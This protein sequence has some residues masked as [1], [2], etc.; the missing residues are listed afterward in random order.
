MYTFATKYCGEHIFFQFVIGS[1][2][3]HYNNIVSNLFMSLEFH[4]GGPSKFNIALC[5]QHDF[6]L[7]TNISLKLKATGQNYE[8]SEKIFTDLITYSMGSLE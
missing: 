8:Y 2:A 4:S 5:G 1:S 3:Q 6:S 7:L